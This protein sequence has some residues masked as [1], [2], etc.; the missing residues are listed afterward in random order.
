[1]PALLTAAAIA[2]L[3]AALAIGGGAAPQAV[4]DPGAAVRYALPVVQLLVNLAAALTIGPLVL[5]AFA[6]SPA[7]P[8]WNRALDTA[9]AA[10]AAW[11]VAAA[12]TGLFA[13]LTVAAPLTPASP[14]F[15]SQLLYFLTAIPL[16]RTWLVTAAAGALLTVL[17]IAVRSHTGSALLA[18]AAIATLIPMALTGHAASAPGDHGN[19]IVALGLHI[20]GAAAWIG[21]LVSVVLLGAR[22]R[23]AGL[24]DLVRRY[25][26]LALVCFVVVG[27]SGIVSA[28]IRLG[29]WGA[30]LTP[31]GALIIVKSLALLAAGVF[32]A[33]YRTALIPRLDGPRGGRVFFALVAGELVVLGVASGFAAALALSPPPELPVPALSTP[34]EILTGQPLPPAPSVVTLLTLWRFDLLWVLGCGALV[35][36]YLAGVLRLRRRG[37]SW[38]IV[39]TGSWLAGVALLFWL[40]NGGLNVYETVLFS[41]HMLL[42]MALAMVVPLL[43]V[44]AAPITLALR[45]VRRRSDGTRG[46]RE[47]ILWAVHSPAG[48]L[49]S[50]P[51]VAAALFGGSLIVFYYSPLFRWATTDHIGH[52]WMTVHFLVSG[53][54]FVQ[55]LVG[56]DPLPYRPAYPFRLLI[57]LVTMAFHA[58]FGLALL[59]SNGLLL[60]EWYGAMGW[61]TSALA[62]Q[63][64]GGAIAWSVGEIPTLVLAILVAVNWAR[65]DER[66]GR[67]LDRAAD[68]SGDA[69]LAAYNDML[70][71]LGRGR[72]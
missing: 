54:L 3:F 40:T 19:A 25:S 17:I 44:P 72:A 32:G 59:E 58:F 39:R 2:A 56:V 16:G 6:L 48:R 69:D 47:W 26:S 15:G 55:A 50:H 66:E 51:L 34:A 45:A 65:S 31:Y 71:R 8:R 49:L 24:V 43:L 4:S 42:H 20:A 21:G 36:F 22:E 5:A 30:L 12:A 53:Y 64:A 27:V 35:V 60:A 13:F 70:A 29:G 7:D 67:R 9:A 63:Q 57:L 52:E 18:A 28:A 62:D 23:G 14:S 1:S 41:S 37:D 10:A 33:V 68:R 46:V 38:P 11:T 61:G